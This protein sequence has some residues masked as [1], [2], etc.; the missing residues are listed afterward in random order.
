[1][2]VQVSSIV[3]VSSIDLQLVQ[4]PAQPF[5]QGPGVVFAMGNET[6]WSSRDLLAVF[7]II[8]CLFFA[9]C[10]WFAL[11]P[12]FPLGPCHPLHECLACSGFGGCRCTGL[13]RWVTWSSPSTFQIGSMPWRTSRTTLAALNTSGWWFSQW[14]RSITEHRWGYHVARIHRQCSSYIQGGSRWKH[15]PTVHSRCQLSKLLTC[16]W[17]AGCTAKTDHCS[18]PTASSCSFFVVGYTHFSW[19]QRPTLH[20]NELL[21]RFFS[22][23]HVSCSRSTTNLIPFFP[24]IPICMGQNIAF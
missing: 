11:E 24:T 20:F 3:A 8:F 10:H 18:L 21:I 9:W 13:F 14:T 4:T 15:L 7:Y 12:F 5:H 16:S 2:H 22:R 1:M 6:K 17:G 19:L 23:I